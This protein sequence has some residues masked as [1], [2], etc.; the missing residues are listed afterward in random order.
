MAP[1]GGKGGWLAMLLATHC[2]LRH[3]PSLKC[4]AAGRKS[5]LTC[6]LLL[7]IP[8]VCELEVPQVLNGPQVLVI[9]RA[10]DSA[11]EGAA[12]L[13]KKGALRAAQGEWTKQG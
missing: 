3:V 8:L 11:R 9:T 6:Q 4:N 7:L 10:Q 12:Q 1:R 2:V 5:C 13:C